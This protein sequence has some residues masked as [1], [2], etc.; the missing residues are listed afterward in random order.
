M[1]TIPVTTNI[2]RLAL[3]PGSFHPVTRA[4]LELAR[5]ALNFADH[6]WFV[7]PRSF[8]H[9]SY[10]RI[11]LRDR[12]ELIEAAIDDP[13]MAAVISEGG[14]FIEIVRE[15]RRRFPSIEKIFVVCGRDAAERIVSWEYDGIEPIEEQ[16]QEYELLVAARNGE[17]RPPEHLAEHI[18]IMR[19]AKSY[20][21]ISATA[22]REKIRQGGGWEEFTPEAIHDRVLELYG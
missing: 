1:Q 14:L 5:A 7:L 10:D 11:T 21:Q 20:D 4:H 13:R 6:V 19:I 16:L 17:F 3:L 2:R 18:H 22:L 12:L 15:C 9:K 8:P